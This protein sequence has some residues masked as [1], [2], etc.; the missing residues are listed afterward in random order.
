MGK[1]GPAPK[2]TNLRVLDGDRKDRINTSEPVPADVDVAPPDWLSED[3]RAV[4]ERLAG[5][6]RRKGVLTGWDVEAYAIYCDAVVR[7]AR[8]A[9]HLEAE[10]E[11]IETPVF[12][13]NGEQTGSRTAKN[14]WALVLQEADSQAQRWSARFGLT[15]SDRAALSIGG[16]QRGDKGRYFSSG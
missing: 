2:P 1:R 15:P 14:P 16:E 3:A 9:R 8:A 11:V 5:D 12:N 6:L 10:G 4:W 7:R 13:K